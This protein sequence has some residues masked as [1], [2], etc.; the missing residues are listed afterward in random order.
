[1]E[2]LISKHAGSE[3]NRNEHNMNL[4]AMRGTWQKVE[5]EHLFNNQYNLEHIRVF[6][7]DI[8]AVRNDVRNGMVHCDN[9][10]KQFKDEEGFKKHLEEVEAK[11]CDCKNIDGCGKKCFWWKQDLIGG[12]RKVLKEEETWNEDHTVQTTESIVQWEYTPFYCEYKASGYGDC[13]EKSCLKGSFTKYTE[14]NVYFLAHPNGKLGAPLS[15]WLSNWKKV[16]DAKDIY[17]YKFKVGSY[18]VL[19]DLDA[20]EHEIVVRNSKRVY[21]VLLKDFMKSVS[22]WY[23]PFLPQCR[24]KGEGWL[25]YEGAPKCNYQTNQDLYALVARFIDTVAEFNQFNLEYS[26]VITQLC[27]ADKVQRV[28]L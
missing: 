3:Y 17:E 27:G 22:R 21:H 25:Y 6:D 4:V 1:M 18:I 26:D 20:A 19:I 15:D 24:V 8:V 5:T 11:K 10:G 12:S 2:V 28:E 16:S 9:C 23:Y 13:A 14:K 7:S